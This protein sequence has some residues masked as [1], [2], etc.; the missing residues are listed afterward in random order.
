MKENRLN[1]KQQVSTSNGSALIFIVIVFMVIMIIATS[2]IAIF[3]NNLKQT[4]QRQNSMEAYYLAY[5]GAEMAFSALMQDEKAKLNELTRINSP[6]P[7]LQQ[8]N[9]AFGNGVINILAKKT[10]ETNFEGW[11]K[12]TATATLTKNNQTY[13]RNLYFDP[14][15]PAEMVWSDN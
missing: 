10:N 11:I 14:L 12:I 9:I 7:Q 2:I 3:S 8:N 1:L 4:K 5:S 13:V 15:N 6:L